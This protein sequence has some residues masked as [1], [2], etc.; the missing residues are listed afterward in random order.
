MRIFHSTT[1]LL[2]AILLIVLVPAAAAQD[3]EP[4]VDSSIDVTFGEELRFRLSAEDV[5]DVE[6][7]RLSFRPELSS[8]QYVVDVPF[9]PGETI[10]VTYPIDVVRIKLKPFGRLKYSWELETGEASISV[11]E[12]SFTYED[13]Q[14]SWLQTSREA[15]TV[16][17]TG[18]GPSFGFDVLNVV[19][20][21]LADLG[22][23]LPLK[24]IVPFDVYVYPSSAELRAGIEAVGL[25]G[26]ETTH[27]DLGV[28]F[29][30]A[31]NPQSAVSDLEQSVP[32]E[33]ARLLIYQMDGE[34]YSD[35]P[36][37]LSEGLGTI[38]QTR[39]NPSYEQVLNEAVQSKSTI[40]LWQLCMSPEETDVDDMLARAQ[41]AAVVKHIR[42][43]FGDQKLADL[44]QSYAQGNDCNVGIRQELGTSLDQLDSA[45][46]NAYRARTPMQQFFSDFALWF[47]ILLAGFAF[48]IMIIRYSTRGRNNN[49]K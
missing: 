13:D 34:H 33:L 22:S 2:F 18:N 45:W 26:E 4:V 11:P 46:L 39:P 24:S 27:P 35:F 1:S 40:P 8:E 12:Q 16:H 5:S 36:W 25:D 44:V 29:V 7:I 28:I 32:Y 23:I 21:A 3:S 10:S 37:W 19:D 31:V 9:E 30:T 15:A 41:S 20:D 17:W 38:F 49:A 48:A 47:L 6:R 14:F 43:R 42:N